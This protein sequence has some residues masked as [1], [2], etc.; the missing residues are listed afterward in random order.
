[1]IKQKF[2]RA[3]NGLL[4]AVMCV[5]TLTAVSYVQPTT[6][7]AAIEWY[8]PALRWLQQD[9][10][11]TGSVLVAN[12][13]ITEGPAHCINAMCPSNRPDG[14]Y[15]GVYT[16]TWGNYIVADDSAGI[17]DEA[18]WYW[19]EQD[20]VWR[21]AKALWDTYEDDDGN[22]VKYITG[23]S[24]ENLGGDN[25]GTTYSRTQMTVYRVPEY[26]DTGMTGK[27]GSLDIVGFGVPADFGN[28]TEGYRSS[29][30]R[31][32]EPG[33]NGL[34]KLVSPRTQGGIYTGHH[35]TAT[36]CESCGIWNSADDEFNDGI[37]NNGNW[38]I[39]ECDYFD[40]KAGQAVPYD[41]QRTYG[42][43]SHTGF[44]KAGE[45]TDDRDALYHKSLNDD[46]LRACKYCFGTQ[47]NVGTET[48][49]N[50]VSAN[51]EDDMY[52]YDDHEF[53][54]KNYQAI[55]PYTIAISKIC[56][57]DA[58][59]DYGCGIEV[60]ENY[61]AENFVNDYIGMVDGEAHYPQGKLAESSLENGGVGVI[62]GDIDKKTL[63]ATLEWDDD[64]P[65][66]R[67]IAGTAT[68][69]YTITY[70][71]PAKYIDKHGDLTNSA[72]DADGKDNIDV[73]DLTTSVT[74]VATVT[75]TP[76]N[77]S[78]S[79]E[80]NKNYYNNNNASGNSSGILSGL[81]GNL[82]ANGW[83]GNVV[84]GGTTV[85]S[86]STGGVISTSAL[87]DGYD[88]II[89]TDAGI[90]TYAAYQP[91]SLDVPDP[92]NNGNT[93]HGVFIETGTCN[94]R[95]SYNGSSDISHACQY[96]YSNNGIDY[97]ECIYCNHW[98]PIQTDSTIVY[99]HS[100]TYYK[101]DEIPATCVAQGKV[102]RKCVCGDI[103]IEDTPIDHSNHTGLAHVVSPAATCENDGY[104]YDQCTGCGTTMNG[105]MIPKLGHQ[106]SIVGTTQGYGHNAS[107]VTQE[108]M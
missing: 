38:G 3:L 31:V 37:L 105:V 62:D 59:A 46:N 1:M 108:E 76:A 75:L 43:G 10:S 33:S 27:G 20:G 100:H 104:E 94:M 9:A 16:D 82:I 51:S 83:N 34:P 56:N 25:T 71:L 14:Y 81:Y 54:T 92:L 55:S 42:H 61:S 79:N 93:L 78:Y 95:G 66:M 44:N 50:W 53:Y 35:F 7:S 12:A 91:S 45:V 60:T 28:R 30:S 102:Y 101:I 99:V 72:K 6:A 18:K 63:T 41:V 96:M 8:N 97:W 74:G 23:Y 88:Y 2:K 87:I 22:E 98:L 77:M 36:Y 86:G 19:T 107:Y 89:D 4:A 67:I 48:S 29:D 68:K 58:V 69:G 84:S 32:Y 85:S 26:T 21:W 13:L 80:G 39:N 24:H 47:K 11:L 65:P 64:E 90:G 40:V 73:S 49:P 70:S 5:S 57:G 103:I 106:W 15:K 52:L 17:T